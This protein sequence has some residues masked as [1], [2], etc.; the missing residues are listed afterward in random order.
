MEDG[1]KPGRPSGVQLGRSS[2]SLVAR[3]RACA[4]KVR[5]GWMHKQGFV[6]RLP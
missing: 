2:G 5:R 1:A 6:L 4:S 3:A